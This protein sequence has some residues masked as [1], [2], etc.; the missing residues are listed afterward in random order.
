MNP[1]GLHDFGRG[2]KGAG[3]YTVPAD[4]TLAFTY[5]VLFHKGDTK[6]AGVAE[7]YAAFAEPPEEVVK[8]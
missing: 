8:W 3:D 5:R 4:K 1:F 2:P 6:T 7:Q